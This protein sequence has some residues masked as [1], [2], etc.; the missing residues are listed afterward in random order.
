M[1]YINAG[2]I[3]AALRSLGEERGSFP[4]Q[5]LPEIEPN[6]YTLPNAKFSLYLE[7]VGLASRN[8][9]QL[10]K[11][12]LRCS[13]CF[14]IF[15]ILHTEFSIGSVNIWN[16][17]TLSLSYYLLD[18]DHVRLRSQGESKCRKGDSHINRTG[19]LLANFENNP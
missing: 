9:V 7:K 4:E 17:F 1:Y 18:E 3:V 6:I 2:S 10:K 13:L 12:I 14:C 11:S 8:I 19:M 16:S 15:H 5:R